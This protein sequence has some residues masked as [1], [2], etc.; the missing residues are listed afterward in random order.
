MRSAPQRTTE[1][2]TMHTRWPLTRLAA[3]LTL[4]ALPLL[5]AAEDKKEIGRAHV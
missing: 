5:A 3:A 2:D 1:V 4:A